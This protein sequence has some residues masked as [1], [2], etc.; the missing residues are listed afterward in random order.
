MI[1]FWKVLT[2]VKQFI[3]IIKFYNKTAIVKSDFND[4]NSVLLSISKMFRLFARA[5]VYVAV[6]IT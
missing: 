2:D 3:S 5:N 1:F 4:L 6:N